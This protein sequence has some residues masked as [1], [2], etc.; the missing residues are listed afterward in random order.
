M[1]WSSSKQF[2]DEPFEKEDELEKVV[3]ELSLQLFGDAR[4]YLDV[5][6]KIGGNGKIKNIPDGYLLDLSSRIE[7]KLYVVENELETHNPLEHIAVQILKF[8]ISFENSPQQVKSIVRDC[9]AKDKTAFNKCA[10]YAVDNGY[11]NIDLLLEKII[12]RPDAFNALVIIDEASEELKKVLWS[13]FKFPVEILTIQ[14]HST[15]SG[16]RMYHFEPFLNDIGG[17]IDPIQGRA[18]TSVSTI[19]PSNLDTVV[20]PAQ[21]EGFQETFIGENRWYQ[22][23]INSSM[24][25]KI[26][27]IAAYRVDPESAITHIAPIKSIERWKDTAKYVLNFS[28]PA[29]S[30]GPIKLLPKPTGKVKALQ[31]PRYTSYERLMKAKNLDEAF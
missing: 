12:H 19:D 8:S 27:F 1:L 5:K 10:R 28:E 30:I 18:T 29:K 2:L 7:P 6:K 26:K 24:I 14:R 25:P 16:E 20:V 11:E 17:E 21:D 3:I 22:I 15:S 13:R 4:F 31:S 23:R 9:L